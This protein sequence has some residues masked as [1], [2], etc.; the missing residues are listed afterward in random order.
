MI[1]F[2]LILEH[3]DWSWRILSGVVSF[4]ELTHEKL[5]G[6]V[7]LGSWYLVHWGLLLGRKR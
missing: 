7:S 4:G 6:V 5:G 1:I 3:V 2:D